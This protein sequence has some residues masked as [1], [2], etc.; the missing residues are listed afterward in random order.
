VDE[1]QQTKRS[2]AT[3]Y[4]TAATAAKQ[5]RR[6][7]TRSHRSARRSGQAT[8]S[9]SKPVMEVRS[10]KLVTQR[11]PLEEVEPIWF[12]RWLLRH[13]FRWRGFACRSHCGECDGKCYAS[14]EYRGVFDDDG[15]AYHAA[16][17]VGGAV[18]P[19][20]FNTALP[21]ETVKYEVGDVPLSEASPWYRRG[22]MLPFEAV[23]RKTI[24]ENL[25]SL[26]LLQ[27][28]LRLLEGRLVQLD[29]CIKGKCV[30]T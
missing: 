15:M 16:R 12:L 2:T 26:R 7:T 24:K 5:A 11:K 23:Q 21:E 17:C 28:S 10:M 29:D 20:P 3:P 22:V 27:A 13:Y 4:V 25:A 30:G 8:N 9:A 14:I 6:R 1:R 19:I 18:K